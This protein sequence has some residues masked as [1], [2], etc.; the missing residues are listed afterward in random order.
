MYHDLPEHERPD[1]DHSLVAR[2]LAKAIKGF[3][4]DV[5]EWAEVE[6]L[7]LDARTQFVD[8]DHIQG[9]SR[10][11]VDALRMLVTELRRGAMNGAIDMLKVQC[12][13][14]M[15]GEYRDPL[16]GL[17]RIQAAI[18]PVVDVIR[19]CYSARLQINAI[20]E[21]SIQGE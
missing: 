5:W 6:L 21:A 11:R 15:N 16:E 7:E 14:V 3:A 9:D 18:L 19:E 20:L 17:A 1:R 12:T 8:I 10:A 2:S 13:A 4:D